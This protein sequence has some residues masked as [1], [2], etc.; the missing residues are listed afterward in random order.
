MSVGDLVRLKN[1]SV[2]GMII[3]F[4]SYTKIDGKVFKK[5]VILW[6]DKKDVSY[7]HSLFLEVISESR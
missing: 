2:I 1:D 3:D 4:V 5:A 6:S 7:E